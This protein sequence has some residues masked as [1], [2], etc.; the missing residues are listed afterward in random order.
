M[1]TVPMFCV[2]GLLM[3]Y[4][5]KFLSRKLREAY[6]AQRRTAKYFAGLTALAGLVQVN[7]WLA[8]EFDGKAP[9]PLTFRVK[10]ASWAKSPF[11]VNWEECKSDEH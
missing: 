3:D 5:D 9:T 10:E 2:S 1:P 4:T 11:L 8:I 6:E 7:E